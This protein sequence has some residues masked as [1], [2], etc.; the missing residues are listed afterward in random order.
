MARSAE[1]LGGGAHRELVEIGLAD[2]DRAG[3]LE[4]FDD[5]RVV[6]GNKPGEDLRRTPS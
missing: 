6:R 4:A 2:D 1:F 3:I 5:G